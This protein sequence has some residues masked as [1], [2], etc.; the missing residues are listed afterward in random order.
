[1]NLKTYLQEQGISASS[2][3]NTLFALAGLYN[4]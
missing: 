2:Y 1:M 4:S 3:L